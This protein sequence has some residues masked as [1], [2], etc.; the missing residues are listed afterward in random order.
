MSSPAGAG[1]H[2]VSGGGT[3]RI[4]SSTDG[5]QRDTERGPAS[6]PQ[7]HWGGL[8]VVIEGSGAGGDVEAR[9]WRLLRPLCEWGWPL[10]PQLICLKYKLVFQAGVW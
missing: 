7:C 9:L 1:P 3:R 10:D 5:A 4:R 6:R 2:G 8:G